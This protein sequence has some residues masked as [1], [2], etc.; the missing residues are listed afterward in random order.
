MMSNTDINKIIPRDAGI[1]VK[2]D[3]DGDLELDRLRHDVYKPNSMLLLNIIEN[4]SL[5]RDFNDEFEL[6]C[7]EELKNRIELL[8]F[9]LDTAKA[10]FT[11]MNLRALLADEVGLGKTIE[12]GIICKELMTRKLIENMLVLSPVTLMDQ[13][14]GEFHDKFNIRLTEPTSVYSVR[15]NNYLISNLNRLSRTGN[16]LGR[17]T[18]G[19]EWDIIII[20]EAHYL[21][22]HR[23]LRYKFVQHLKSKYLILLTATPIQNSMR[24]LYNIMHLLKPGTLGTFSSFK[25]R[26]CVGGDRDVNPYHKDELRKVVHSNMIR[27]RRA[28]VGIDFGLRVPKDVFL[29]Q[30]PEEWALYSAILKMKISSLEKVSILKI[31]ASSAAALKATLGK[32]IE[33][34]S[35]WYEL[36]YQQ[37]RA[38]QSS[39]MLDIKLKNLNDI[40]EMHEKVVVFVEYNAT[41]DS[42]ARWLREEG[43]EHSVLSGRQ[44]TEKRRDAILSFKNR[45]RVFI[46]SPAGM[47]GLNLQF[48]NVVVNY[49]LPWNPMRVEQRI[50][51]V[52]RIGQKRKVYIYNL[53]KNGTIEERIIRLLYQKLNLFH[54][55]IGEIDAILE[56]MYGENYNFDK[57]IDQIVIR[58]NEIEDIDVSFMRLGKDI[59]R[60]RNKFGSEQ[61]RI[62]QVMGGKA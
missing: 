40:V 12:A 2:I 21:K 44:N 60:G 47:E 33:S 6:L 46:S 14:Q 42:I 9:Q 7:I 39:P 11:R 37:M 17:A 16:E 53:V 24:E 10:A 20:D 41:L 38:M 19:R 56:L 27:H 35:G 55:S 36:I 25:G 62:D 52:H 26:Y 15:K 49:D 28:D 48:A 50:G 29:E 61:S 30:T 31:A 45:G 22:N 34:R 57:T 3:F 5:L 51:R 13:W 23:T 59:E 8:E 43:I 1:R 32:R 54:M 58:S 18:M 4:I